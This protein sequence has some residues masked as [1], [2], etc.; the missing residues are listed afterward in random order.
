MRLYPRLSASRIKEIFRR[1]RRNGAIAKRFSIEVS[2]LMHLLE[3]AEAH[4]LE[5]GDGNFRT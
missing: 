4:S 2:K 3:N 5:K 1:V